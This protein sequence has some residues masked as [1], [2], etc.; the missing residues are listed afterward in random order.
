MREEPASR[1]AQIIAEMRQQAQAEARAD[2]R[3][4]TTQIEAERQQAIDSLRSEVGRLATDLAVADRRG[5][6][7][8]RGAP[9]PRRRAL[10]GRPRGRAGRAHYAAASVQ[11]VLMQGSSRESLAAGQDRLETLLRAAGVDR[12]AVGDE[13]FAVTGVLDSNA[14]AAP[15]PDRPLARRRA[16]KA[17]L[18]DAA[19]SDG[20]CGRAVDLV[21]GM[22]AARWSRSGDLA[23]AIERLAVSGVLAAAEART[24]ST[25]VE[26]ELFRFGR[27]V[28][29][30]PELRDALADR[31][32]RGERKAG[33]VDDAARR[34]GHRPRPCGWPARRS[35]APR[36]ASLDASLEEYGRLAA[37][38]RQRLVAHVVVAAPLDAAQQ[39]PARSGAGRA[40]GRA[41]HA[42]RRRRSR[43][44]SAAS[45][46]RSATRSR[47]HRRPPAGR[48]PPRPGG[49]A[50]P[51]A[52]LT[53]TL[54]HSASITEATTRAQRAG[55]R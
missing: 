49:L 40:Y 55:T 5:V 32:V 54:N 28:D 25:R 11:R 52:P 48:R 16:A 20:R 12:A 22:V 10:P 37:E 2:H 8:G 39:R 46:S 7:R 30:D 18:V 47:R 38:R 1:A 53:R 34:Q 4:R 33:L 3:R 50:R 43:R 23:D 14:D 19:A 17:A 9:A 24:A 29:G 13:L 44:S 42:E 6:A 31:T 15:G 27:M 51:P 26:D 41:V 21:A 45:G 35:L 36:G